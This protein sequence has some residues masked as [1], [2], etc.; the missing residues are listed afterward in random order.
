MDYKNKIFHAFNDKPTKIM[1]E[2]LLKFPEKNIYDF[3]TSNSILNTIF[4]EM[5]SKEKVK[6][7]GL[8]KVV[9]QNIQKKPVIE[10][11]EVNKP[12]LLV[13]EATNELPHEYEALWNE[14]KRLKLQDKVV[15]TRAN[16]VKMES[17]ELASSIKKIILEEE[18]AL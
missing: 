9:K 8:F 5:N 17:L 14:Y 12:L 15:S 6:F 1:R 7:K 4:S 16:L 13:N 2:F 10:E 11:K 3:I 18:T